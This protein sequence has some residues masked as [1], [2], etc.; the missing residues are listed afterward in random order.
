VALRMLWCLGGMARGLWQVFEGAG[1]MA[2]ALRTLW[3][4]SMIMHLGWIEG[5]AR[6]PSFFL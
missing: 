5:R 3:C 4:L 2:L 1:E 6:G